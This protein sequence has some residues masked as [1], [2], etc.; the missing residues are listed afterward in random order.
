MEVFEKSLVKFRYYALDKKSCLNEMVEHLH[1]EGVV[2]DPE[3][4]FKAIL[5]REKL[6]ST[7]IG[8]GVAIPHAR[9]DAVQEL[10]IAAYLLDNELDFDSIDGQPVKIIF[11]IAVPEDMK[12]AYMKVLSAISNF[13]RKDEN[14]SRIIKV[15]SLEEFWVI[16]QELD[17]EI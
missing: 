11:M 14:R 10:K 4:F 13:F 5:E 15:V 9:S 12:E 17:D 2:K 16:L 6:M 8:R 1:E 7:G 3:R